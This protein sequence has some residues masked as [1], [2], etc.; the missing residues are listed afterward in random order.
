ML[1]KKILNQE[2]SLA[3]EIYAEQLQHDWP[4]LNREVKGICENIGVKN[5]N[6]EDVSKEEVEE[7]IYYHDYKK[8]KIEVSGYKKLEAIKNDD[9]TELPDYM[10]DKNI[11]NSRMAFRINS[12][13]VNKIK[14][15]F[16]GSY[17]EN[18]TC[19]KCEIGENETQCH[20][21]TCSGWAE[22]R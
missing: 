20:A 15:N 9:F 19:E 21:M 13:M 5:I 1:A 8:L 4:G 3:K 17:K 14:M 6:E 11:E 22:Q 18:L 16:K 2:K 7:G 10:N 12:G